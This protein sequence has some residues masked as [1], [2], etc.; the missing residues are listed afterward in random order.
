MI[1]P[2]A[3]NHLIETPEADPVTGVVR[4]AP[5]QSLWNGAMMA[6]TLV[7]GP[8]TA[9]PA[10]V[11]AFVLTTGTTLLLGHSVG[12]HRRLI[13]GSF[14]CPLWLEHAL[15][16]CGAL[17]GMSGPFGIIRSHDMRDWAQRRADCHPYL[18]HGSFWL[19]DAWW[20][21]HCRLELKTPP[22]FDLGRVGRDHFYRSLE[23]SWMAQQLPV[24]ALLF[25]A[26]GWG[27]VVWGVCA[28][29]FVSVHGHWLIGHLAHNSGPQQ[30][31]VADAG[32]QAHDVPWAGL[33][34]M[35]EAWHNNHHAFPGSAQIG[36][37]PGQSD[38]G[39]AFIRMLERFGLAWDVRT[40]ETAPERL[41]ALR[42]AET[43][44]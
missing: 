32:V 4:W 16:W 9:S 12:Y 22:R 11:A 29:I 33:I 31:V 37:Y 36:L 14:A 24:A 1:D 43:E 10:A 44:R 19:K 8:P 40:A 6:A 34:T 2:H 5:A 25:W 42:P 27:C 18:R 17:V 39:Y 21:L 15:V 7:L 35:G 28:R 13:H 41:S 23:A 26:G 38:L 20:Q 3:V 30:W